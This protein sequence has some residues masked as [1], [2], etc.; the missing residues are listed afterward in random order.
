MR[1]HIKWNIPLMR[2]IFNKIYKTPSI[3]SCL[4]SLSRCSREA[5]CVRR[6]LIDVINPAECLSWHIV[7]EW[8]NEWDQCSIYQQPFDCWWNFKKIFQTRQIHN[9]MLHYLW[10]S[11]TMIIIVQIPSTT[12]YIHDQPETLNKQLAREEKILWNLSLSNHQ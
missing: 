6:T 10:T 3:L 12:S 1:A 9:K 11:S 4:L 8:C 5:P 7:R 2:H